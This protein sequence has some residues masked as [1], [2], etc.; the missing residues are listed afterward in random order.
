MNT[1]FIHRTAYLLFHSITNDKHWLF[2]ERFVLL[3][4]VR[5]E[6]NTALSSFQRQLLSIYWWTVLD[7]GTI[8]MREV[9]KCVFLRLFISLSWEGV[10]ETNTLKRLRTVAVHFILSY[11]CHVFRTTLSFYILIC[12]LTFF[13]N[14]PRKMVTECSRMEFFLV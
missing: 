4:V 14:V 5:F 8:Q 13:P 3:L 10:T 2:S 9:T 12:K 6:M 11:C 1:A 7:E